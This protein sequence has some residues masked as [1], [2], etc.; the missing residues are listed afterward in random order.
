MP[1][2]YTAVTIEDSTIHLT[3]RLDDTTREWS[4]QQT[5]Q[6]S[7]LAPLTEFLLFCGDHP[8]VCYR[9]RLLTNLL[10]QTEILPLA[11]KPLGNLIDLFEGALVAVPDAPGYALPALARHLSLVDPTSDEGT[12]RSAPLSAT[13]P[14]TCVNLAGTLALLPHLQDALRV[15]FSNL[16]RELLAILHYER[17]DP[18]KLAWLPWPSLTT[19]ERRLA[20]GHFS[21]LMPVAGKPRRLEKEH[22]GQLLPDLSRDLLAADGP[23]ASAFPAYEE[24]PAQVDMA[25]AVAETLQDGGLLMVEAGTGV[26]KS[27]AYLIPAVLWAREHGEPVIISTNTRNLQ[28]QLINKDLPVLSQALP[29]SF[30]AALLKGR[31]NYPCLRTF[32]WMLGDVGG[33]LFWNEH[34][35]LMHLTAWL[36]T[37]PTGDLETLAPEVAEELDTLGPTIDRLRSQGASCVG[38]ACACH[39]VCRVDQAREHARACD[40]IVINHALAF[41]DAEGN[42]LP[43]HSRLI[44]DEAQNIESVATDGLSHEISAPLL[45]HLTRLLGLDGK[46][47][48]MIEMLD[49]RRQPHEDHSGVGPARQILQQLPT[50]LADMVGAGEALGIEV[51][52]FCES[53][54]RAGDAGRC[55]VRLTREARESEEFAPVASRGA[56]FIHEATAAMASLQTLQETLAEIEENS[57]TELQGISADAMAI[58]SRLQE[59]SAAAEIV[60]DGEGDEEDYVSWAETWDTRNGGWSLRAAPVDVGPLLKDLFYETKHSVVFTSATLSVAGSFNHFKYRVGLQLTGSRLREE[61]FPSPF[62]LE[63]QLLLCV[64]SDFPD[65]R[66]RSFNDVVHAALREICEVSNGGTL[67]LFT[68]RTRLRRAFED[69][70]EPLERLGLRPLCQDLSGPRWWLLDQLRQDDKTVLFGLK[71]FWEGVDVPGSALRCVVL[72]KLPFAVPDDP[73]VEARKEHVRRQGGNPVSDYY[74]PEAIVGFKQGVGRLIRTRTDH[75]VVFVLDPRLITKPYGRRFFRSI[76]RC[77]LCRD[78]LAVCLEQAR[79]WLRDA[80]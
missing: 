8:I 13:A 3:A 9:A 15:R 73:I 47:G 53:V 51:V 56:E 62:D 66:D 41:A 5:R 23:I 58:I 22:T 69:L 80:R 79:D 7:G 46:P 48:G 6:R 54:A 45:N 26:G 38:R 35:A 77:A 61:S 49:K 28:E 72:A 29:V 32:S 65:P 21:G 4:W 57:R 74:I 37:S 25:G 55:S 2:I 39:N 36:A 70:A 34:L 31:G 76:Q 42:V 50:A 67:I 52:E 10:S 19:E 24:R 64:P 14:Q 68:A 20:L 78:E 17:G 11:R 40:V 12:G 1:Y 30:Q 75:G 60:L 43:E 44:F 71:S 59:I 33:S 27:L 18:Q 63:E 16:P